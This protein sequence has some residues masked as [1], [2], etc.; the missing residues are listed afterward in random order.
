MNTRTEATIAQLVSH[1]QRGFAVVVIGQHGCGKMEMCHQAV[2]QMGLEPY[3]IQADMMDMSDLHGLPLPPKDGECNPG[4]TP[5]LFDKLPDGVGL[6]IDNLDKMNSDLVPTFALHVIEYV[7][8]GI[9]KGE[10]KVVFIVAHP[11]DDRHHTSEIISEW[12]R[13]ATGETLGLERLVVEVGK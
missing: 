13:P 9:L 6:I 11:D 5:G 4:R 12:F 7:R 2:K 10:K 3:T 1:V 8:R